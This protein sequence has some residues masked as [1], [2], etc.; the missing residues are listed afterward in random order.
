MFAAL[1]QR[2]FERV[3]WYLLA[4]AIL[5]CGFQFLIVGIAGDLQRSGGFSQ[6]AALIP[7]GL[8]EMSGGLMFSTFTGLTAFGLIDPVIV[9]LLA[10]LAVFLA[11]EPA[12]EVDAGVVDL[13]LARPVPRHFLLLRTGAIASV[14]IAALALLAVVASR[15]ALLVFAPAGIAWPALSTMLRLALNLSAI[16]WW[17]AAA[18]LLTATLSRRRSVPVGAIGLAAVAFY[19]LH[20]VTQ[21]WSK[22]APLRVL[23]PYYYYNAPAIL[24]QSQ[25]TFARDLLILL[26]TAV[27]FTVASW[28]VY[29]RRDV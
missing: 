18:S 10:Q 1:L 25:A 20:I 6:L 22:A 9:V 16:G 24:Q 14:S 12:W 8:A 3:R 4:V 28:R 27:A 13:L 26:G 15:A 11:S 19:L 23:T 21:L 17:F 29:A 7:P 2:G 5:V